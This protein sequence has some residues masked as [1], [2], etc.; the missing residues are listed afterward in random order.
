[1]S[2]NALVACPECDLV[3]HEPPAAAGTSVSCLRCG[4]ILFHSRDGSLDRTLALTFGAGIL[5]LLANT[6]PLVGIEIQGQRSAVTLLGAVQRLWDQDMPLVAALVFLTTIAF[7][8]LELT[9]IT[10]LLLPLKFGHR[11]A[12]FAAVFRFVDAVR[13]WGMVEVFVLGVLVSLVKLAHLANVEPGIALWSFGGLI[14]LLAAEA[15]ALDNRDL[16]ARAE[17]IG[18]GA[19]V[20]PKAASPWGIP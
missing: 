16:W 7:P 18:A 20:R 10:Y 13:P 15:T 19:S 17:A 5:F 6:F 1:M 8:A 2:R 9:A 11:P 4:A 3:Q 12:G 14:L